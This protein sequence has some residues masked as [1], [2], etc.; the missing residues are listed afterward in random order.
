MEKAHKE[1]CADPAFWKEFE[2]HY[3]YMNRPSRLYLAE[4]LTEHAGGANI[5][6]KRE[7]LY[8]LRPLAL[9]FL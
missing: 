2:S 3:G 4:R 6:F 1:A 7:D 9:T 5:W 8:V